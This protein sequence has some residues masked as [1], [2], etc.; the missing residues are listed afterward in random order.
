M[1]FKEES[2]DIWFAALVINKGGH[3]TDYLRNGNRITFIMEAAFD[4]RQLQID[5]LVS[6]TVYTSSSSLHH[7]IEL[8]VQLFPLSLIKY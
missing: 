2:K 3:I 1:S 7:H 6:L 4:I 5:F 8:Q